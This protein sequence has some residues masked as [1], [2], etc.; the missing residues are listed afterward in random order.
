MRYALLVAF[1]LGGRNDADTFTLR[2]QIPRAAEASF[3]EGTAERGAVPVSAWFH[4]VK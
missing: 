2:H 4:G 1:P 3:P